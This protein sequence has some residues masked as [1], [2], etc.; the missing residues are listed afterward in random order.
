MESVADG[1]AASSKQL[2]GSRVLKVL[3]TI[4]S[5]VGAI[6]SLVF[7][8][9][10][11]AGGW[12]AYHNF[13]AEKWETEKQLEAQRETIANLSKDLEAKQRE[14]ERLDVALRLLKVDHRVAQI[15]VISQQGSPDSGDLVTSFTFVEVDPQGNPIDR[16][17][18]FSVKG[19]LVYVESWVVKFTD[20]Y[21]EM[22]DPLRSTSL[23]LFRRVFGEKQQPA[24]GFV[25]DPE[26]LRPAAYHNGGKPSELEQEIWS[27][28]WQY[29][30]DPALAAKAGV[31]AA[32]GEAPFQKLI[33][34]KR[35]KVLLRASGGLSFAPPEDIPP[36]EM[37]GPKPETL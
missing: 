7:L 28:F 20:K 16:P 5:L 17:R 15:D 26:G 2:K 35:Y 33:P 18:L 21:I 31:R 12:F 29:A 3:N 36:E 34:G 22:G 8:A 32:H 14:I 1:F 37:P 19:D 9:A 11:G 30:N 24:E 4:N 13:L 23:C 6:V 10:L 27:K 25:L